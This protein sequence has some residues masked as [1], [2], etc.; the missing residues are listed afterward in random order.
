MFI[1]LHIRGITFPDNVFLAG[2]FY[3]SVLN[4][5]FHSF[6]TC[7]VSAEKYADSQMGISL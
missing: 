7:T 3:L 5:L 2:D 1:Y 6:L 4:I